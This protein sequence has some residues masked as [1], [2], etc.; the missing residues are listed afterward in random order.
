M[1]SPLDHYESN[2]L[3]NHG[4]LMAAVLW[5]LCA[6]CGIFLS[7]RL[8]VRSRYQRPWWDDALLTLGWISLFGE[9]L[10]TQIAINLGFGKHALDINVAHMDTLTY[11]SAAALS[12]STLA[13]NS[14]K[15]S[16]ALTLV[17]LTTGPWRWYLWFA[18]LS[19]VIFSIPVAIL[20]W[21]QCTP[22]I[23][24]FVDFWPGVC[25]DRSISVNYGI[26]QATWAA[27]MDFSFACIP[28]KVLWGLQMKKV[29]RIAIGIAM[30]LGF[31][32]GITAIMRSVYTIQLYNM[33]ISYD[34]V[35]AIVWTGVESTTT[36]VAASIPIL[37]RFV[38]DRA[39][40]SNA[41]KLEPYSSRSKPG[42]E[43]SKSG[44]GQ[45]IQSSH[46]SV[47]NNGSKAPNSLYRVEITVGAESVRSIL[48]DSD[49]LDEE[50]RSI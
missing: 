4:P 39:K 20:P 49:G 35:K 14:S 48:G 34:S 45:G 29:E 31:L 6:F 26:F 38:S 47:R 37:R 5:S 40:A 15:I 44:Q 41:L 8:Y 2:P 30:S 11:Y 22:I 10:C 9:V 3:E 13:I 19:L 33:D 18:M 28:W 32:A 24:T 43:R 21:V 16:F 46:G 36:I 1:S 7:L 27:L 50:R 12:L 42:E 23:K 25:M 17:P